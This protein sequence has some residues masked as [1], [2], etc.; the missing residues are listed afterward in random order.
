MDKLNGIEITIKIF[1]SLP[2]SAF[3]LFAIIMS[4]FSFPHP[5]DEGHSQQ[6]YEM[7]ASHFELEAVFCCTVQQAFR[8]LFVRG[9][10]C[11]WNEIIVLHR[12]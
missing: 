11:K 7:M 9:F 4:L 3:F 8:P 1:P 6:K 12:R 5:L 10:F 2:L